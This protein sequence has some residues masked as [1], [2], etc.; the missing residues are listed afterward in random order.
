MN[1]KLLS[2]LRQNVFVMQVINA[3]PN[4]HLPN[5]Y[6]AGACLAQTIWN[7]AHHKEAN[8]DIKDIDLVYFDADL[9]EEKEKTQQAHI[10]TIFKNKPIQVDLIN[11]ARVHLWYKDSFGYDIKP[12]TSTEDAITTFPITAGV[13]G[14]RKEG[15]G[16]NIFAPLGLDDVFNL[17]VR[18]NKKQITREIYEAKLKRWQP[19]WPTLTYLSWEES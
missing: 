14:I 15:N 17:V 6:V 1:N 16:Y 5:C 19:C 7:L 8:S 9:S 13:V 3:I 18:A 10:R 12:Y 4:L 11:E 2:G